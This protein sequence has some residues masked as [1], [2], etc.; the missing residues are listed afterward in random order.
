M[1]I[2][3]DN[4]I[5][6]KYFKRI[7]STVSDIDKQFEKQNENVKISF[8]VFLKDSHVIQKKYLLPF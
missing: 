1:F 6:M 5:V 2:L 4:Q 3:I 7:L 8:L